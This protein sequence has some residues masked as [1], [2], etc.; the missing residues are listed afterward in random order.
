MV[1]KNWILRGEQLL[2][3]FKVS[4]LSG[5]WP[6]KDEVG[7]WKIYKN[8]FFLKCNHHFYLL[9]KCSLNNNFCILWLRNIFKEIL[10]IWSDINLKYFLYHS[11]CTLFEICSDYQLTIVYPRIRPI[12]HH[13][14]FLT[15]GSSR[16]WVSRCPWLT[17]DCMNIFPDSAALEIRKNRTWK[18]VKILT[19]PKSENLNAEH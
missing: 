11:V 15:P 18:W 14:V 13:L 10:K 1:S 9:L 2:F 19:L 12:I 4:R 8:S 5:N 16:F 7:S 6:Q 3:N 17:A